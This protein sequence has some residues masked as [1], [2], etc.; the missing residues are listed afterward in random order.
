[1]KNRL[2]PLILGLAIL[3]AACSG[4][5]GSASDSSAGKELFAQAVIG[6]QAGCAACHSLEPGVVVI[7]PSL[8]GIGDRAG[9]V[10]AGQSAADYL[11][12]SITAPDAHIADGFPASIMPQEY[13]EELSS[14]QIDQLVAYMLTLK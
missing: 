14:E 5:G 10:V 4:S 12:E 13:T 3:L 2:L 1:M 7:G 8:A 11:K 9:E 6:S